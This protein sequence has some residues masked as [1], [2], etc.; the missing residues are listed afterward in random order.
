MLHER[1]S[2]QIMLP[3]VGIDGQHKLAES[4]V[5]II[6]LGG[7]GAAVATYLVGA[8][9]GR[10]GLADNDAVSFSNL[11]RQVLYTEASV[12]HSKVVEAV[13]RLSA[14]SS[15]T[16]FKTYPDGIAKDNAMN[17]I[18]GYDLVADCTDNY[19]TRYLIDDACA[20]LDKPW[21]YGSIG[22]F[23]GQVAIMNY[24]RKRRYRDLYDDRES[25]CAL[26]FTAKGVIGAV[27]GVVGAIQASE[28]V[29]LICGF[30]ELLDGR[31]FTIDL[32][33]LQT[34]IFEF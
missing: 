24:R 31:L 17:I 30:G 26:P 16:I 6:G 7:L 19:P 18:K 15:A 5:L 9:V 32:K 8:G 21:I 10:I 33:T 14:Q 22:E 1:Y 4:S 13:K 12:G 23:S 2:R 29:K 11:Q 20:E 25:L 3:D 34:F 27:P 28:A